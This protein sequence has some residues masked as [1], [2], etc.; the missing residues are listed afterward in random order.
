MLPLSAGSGAEGIFPL[1]WTYVTSALAVLALAR[2]IVPQEWLDRVQEWFVGLLSS[3]DPFCSFTFPEYSG[4][5][6]DQHYELVKLYLG[7]K[8]IFGAKK[9][10]VNLPRNAKQALFSLADGE[11]FRDEVSEIL[12]TL[13]L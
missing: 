6:L 8:D 5:S 13:C 11:S 10:L 12:K 9:V 7:S 3:L 4:A 2:A 1:Y